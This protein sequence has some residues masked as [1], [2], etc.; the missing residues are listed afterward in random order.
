MKRRIFMGTKKGNG[1]NYKQTFLIGFGFMACMLMWSVYNSYVPVIFRAK[2][3]ELTDG[4]S[5]LPAFLSVALL[6]NA[7]M[8]IDN[9]FGVI[10]QPY[11]GKK[12][13]KTHTKWGKRMPYI[14]ICLPICAVFFSLIPVAAT[15]K[16]AALSVGLMM[17]VIILFNF[18]MSVWRSPVVSLMPDFT[19]SPLQSDANAVI[20][21][22]GGIGQ[23]LGFVIGSIATALVG[24]L[25]FTALHD[26]L[27]AKTNTLGQ[28]LATDANGDVVIRFFS[29]KN[30]IDTDTL[31][32]FIASGRD[33]LYVNGQKVAEKVAALNRHGE[34]TYVNYTPVFVVAAVITVLCLLVLCLFYKKNKQNDLS[35]NV[36]IEDEEGKNKK[37]KIKEL[38]ISKAERK[39]LITMLAALFLINNATEAI[40]PNF[41]NFAL[42]T[43]N[44]KPIYSTLM[45]AVFAVSLAAFGIPAGAMGRKLGRK[46]TIIIGLA[47]IVAMFAFYIAVSQLFATN[48]MFV[49]IVLWIALVVGGAAVGCININTLPL[50]LAIGGREYVGTFTGYYYTATFSA[51][52]TGPIL[53]GALIGLFGDDYNFMFLFCA[54]FFA[55]GLAV[56]TQVKHGESNPDDE[57][58]IQAAVEAADD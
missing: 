49:W 8:T 36:S 22:M 25:G 14:I 28:V 33:T 20:N 34:P 5:K 12:S 43:L 29:D 23:M 52:I 45:M 26:A 44:V 11:F 3:T 17:A 6:V 21:I 40:V 46:K 13:D 7:I 50:V 9:I 15:V 24:L 39:S 31:N 54:I 57:E 27:R 37:V 47:V 35:K 38:P 55:I 48:R 56:I 53:C 58:W 41:T 32:N 4:G 30:S 19:P 10:F 16:A 1:L 51:A 18:T 42:D 2:L